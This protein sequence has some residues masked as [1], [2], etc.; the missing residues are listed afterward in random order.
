M[1]IFSSHYKEEEYDSRDDPFV[2]HLFD[3]WLPEKEADEDFDCTPISKIK[4]RKGG[5]QS[6]YR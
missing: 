6:E 5:K 3:H 4:K 1:G 2:S